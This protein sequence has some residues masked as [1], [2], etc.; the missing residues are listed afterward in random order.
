MRKVVVVLTGLLVLAML[1][2][3]LVVWFQV[4]WTW[5]LSCVKE[6]SLEQCREFNLKDI[7]FQIW[8]TF[9][10]QPQPQALPGPAL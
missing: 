3:A 1:V 6:L 8:Q 7:V 10:S 2:W 5:A 4:G 9:Y